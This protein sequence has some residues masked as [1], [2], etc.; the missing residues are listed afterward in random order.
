MEDK[1]LGEIFCLSSHWLIYCPFPS[2]FAWLPRLYC[3]LLSLLLSARDL[4]EHH[5]Q[6]ATELT[7]TRNSTSFYWVGL[8]FSVSYWFFF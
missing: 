4:T 6:L 7:S 8:V 1:M 2:V 3:V 5:T